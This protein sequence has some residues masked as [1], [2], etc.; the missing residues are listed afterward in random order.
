[1][2]VD[3]I[4]AP[5]MDG[6]LAGMARA[7]AEETLRRVKLEAERSARENGSTQCLIMGHC[8]CKANTVE[9]EEHKVH[10]EKAKQLVESWGFFPWVA[11][12]IFN[13]QW[14]FIRTAA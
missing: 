3:V 10:L 2:E 7:D 5:G 14:E 8:N 1:M 9:Y 11:T 13:P 6:I 4:T 12:G